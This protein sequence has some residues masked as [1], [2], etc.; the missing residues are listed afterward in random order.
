MLVPLLAVA[1]KPFNFHVTARLRCS[2]GNGEA[3]NSAFLSIAMYKF[4]QEM[5]HNVPVKHVGVVQGGA[6]WLD[7]CVHD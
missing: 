3:L 5:A 7:V 1:G 2:S 6:Q 4:E